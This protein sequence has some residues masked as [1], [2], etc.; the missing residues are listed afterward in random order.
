MCIVLVNGNNVFQDN[1]VK[2]R[3]VIFV[4]VYFINMQKNDIELF[5]LRTPLNS[6]RNLFLGP[7][8]YEM[9]LLFTQIW[10]VLEL[11]SRPISS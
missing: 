7:E 11:F 3:V 1:H 10:P 5:Y 6:D 2:L 9:K 4:Y 8:S